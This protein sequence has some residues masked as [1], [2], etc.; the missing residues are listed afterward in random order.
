[1]ANNTETGHTQNVVNFGTLTTKCTNLGDLFKPGNSSLLVPSLNQTWLEGK[2]I[3]K[4]YGLAEADLLEAINNRKVMYA[5]VKKLI[6]RVMKNLKSTDVTELALEDIKSVAD[7]I[8]GHRKTGDKPE[9]EELKVGEELPKSIS[10][11]KQSFVNKANNVEKFA[12]LLERTPSY[13]P[14]EQDLTVASLQALAQSLVAANEDVSD[15]EDKYKSALGQRDKLLYNKEKG[16]IYV[17]GKAKFYAL[18]ILDP[19]SPEYKAL[20]K[21]KFVDL[22]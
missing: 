19:N 13:N 20:L 3:L 4:A 17:G 16:L 12:M 2:N 11:S 5:P 9:P 14:N 7:R 22:S 21:I 10:T 18:S 8:R 6:T 1:M 15:K